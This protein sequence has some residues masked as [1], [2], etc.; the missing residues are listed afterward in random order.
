MSDEIS[1]KD[2]LAESPLCVMG[3]GMQAV[4]YLLPSNQVREGKD[5]PL[6]H[7]PRGNGLWWELR[8]LGS[9]LLSP[10]KIQNKGEQTYFVNDQV[11]N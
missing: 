7:N 10:Q 6:H 1:F 4:V 3:G 5:L 9:D 2:V 11:V 8:G